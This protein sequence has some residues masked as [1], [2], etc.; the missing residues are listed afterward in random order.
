MRIIEPRKSLFCFALVLGILS[1]GSDFNRCLV[2]AEDQDFEDEEEDNEYAAADDVV[3]TI[4]DDTYIDLSARDFNDVTVMPV[5]CVN[6]MS[7]QM[8]KFQYFDGN[9]NLQCHTNSL[10]TY[11]SSIS[12]YM[13][14]YFNQQALLL[15]QNF[16]LPSDAGYLNC[17]MVQETLYS[18]QKLYAKIGCLE[19]DTYTSTKLRLHL[20]TDN[21]CSEAYDDGQTDA[22]RR[23]KGYLVDGNYYSTKVSFRPPFYK[24]L[25][26]GTSK[27]SESFSKQG[28]Y[29]Y[30][31]DAVANGNQLAK[32][33]DVYDYELDDYFVHDDHYYKVQNYVNNQV[34]QYKEDDDDFYTNDD[35]SRRLNEFT[36]VKGEME[37]FT[38]EFWDDVDHNRRLED[39]AEAAADDQGGDDSAIGGWN[40]C[41]QI[42]KYGVWCDSYCRSLDIFHVDQWSSSDI[43]LMGVMLTFMLGMFVLVFAKRVKSYQRASILV[44]DFKTT[45]PGLPPMALLLGFAL[46]L[47]TIAALAL[48]R[49]VNETL[50]VSVVC[51]I[52]LFV[53]MLKLS[54]FE[55]KNSTGLIP[56]DGTT[57]DNYS[58]NGNPLFA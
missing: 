51:C 50:V 1:F 48:M 13:R 32:Y 18:D 15:G 41:A 28:T 56:S 7:G 35:D 14:A 27:I 9:R 57:I 53:Y 47:T 4:N 19:R 39:A 6:Y 52:L 25:K 24:C 2:A 43:I 31:D 30:D 38:T 29:W 58:Y 37:A 34:N 26:C 10:G 40:M 36:P 3:G 42:F 33:D 55:T 17:V 49:L 16:E 8:I 44:D 21:Q 45:N 23:N 46:V 22:Q 20:Y 12:H 11:V 5:S 54:L